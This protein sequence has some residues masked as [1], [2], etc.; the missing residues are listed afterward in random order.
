[1]MEGGLPQ[2]EAALVVQS[3]NFPTGEFRGQ[4]W[5][6]GQVRIIQIRHG[7][8]IAGAVA[9][10]VGEPRFR[11]EEVTAGAISSDRPLG[12][13]DADALGRQIRTDLLRSYNH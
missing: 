8:F 3:L 9:E 10:H 12:F 6:T 1:M 2:A 7:N 5:Q 4:G 11:P 13:N